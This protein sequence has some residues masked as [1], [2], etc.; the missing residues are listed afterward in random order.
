MRRDAA[1]V[2]L[3]PVFPEI[4]ALP[5]DQRQGA[6][7]DRDVQANHRQRNAHVRRHVAV[8]LDRMPEERVAVGRQ[9]PPA[10]VAAIVKQSG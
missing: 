10:Y 4:N 9:S 6:T 7:D 5:C 1:R 8:T 2:Q 3:M